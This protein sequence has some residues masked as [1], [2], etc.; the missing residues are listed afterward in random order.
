MR[1]DGTT[2]RTE[3]LMGTFV[4]IQVVGGASWDAGL[5]SA[6]A[7]E[8]RPPQ[9]GDGA[10][11]RSRRIGVEETI[12]RAFDWFAR[13][14]A[15]CT[16]FDPAS[17]LMQLT[18]QI[19][20]AVPVSPLLYAAVE[21]ALAVAEDSGGAFDPTV[22]HQMET[23]G[24]TREHRT[25]SLIR[26][27]ITPGDP[28]YRD[29]RVDPAAQTI[30]LLRPLI[31]DLGAVA[32]GLAIDL[33]ALELRELGDY[34]I[35]AGGDLYLAGRNPA[36]APWSAGIRHPRDEHQL[37][38]GIR[39][40]NRAVCTSGDYER[41]SALGDHHILDP[42]TGAPTAGVASATVVAPTAMLA[43]ALATA[44][45]VL[46]PADGLRLLERHGVDGMIVSESATGLER[47]AT[48]GMLSDYDLGH[49]AVPVDSPPLA[50]LPYAEGSAPR[51]AGGP[52]PDR[53]AR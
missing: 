13:V 16:R 38:A 52:G 22:G 1:G 25:G 28:T 20:V 33:A 29:V 23:R 47:H 27:T 42:R 21:F 9:V 4:T 32:K 26:T 51:R 5:A 36:G 3:V 7:I 11:N 12:Q 31:L 53:R 39:V 17:E 37:L 43:D 48:R 45:L 44:A 19:G 30:T 24:F 15:C 18:T 46:G 10:G 14:E 50:I 34:A 40:S 35:D 49:E 8:A 2:I 41:R 6:D